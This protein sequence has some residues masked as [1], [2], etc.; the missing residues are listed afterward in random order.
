MEAVLHQTQGG[1]A[2]PGVS[3]DPIRRCMLV[4]RVAE[5]LNDILLLDSVKRIVLLGRCVH[6]A[7]QENE[8]IK[9]MI[10]KTQC[11]EGLHAEAKS[12][13]NGDVAFPAALSLNP[14]AQREVQRV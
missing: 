1:F 8:A 14:G 7:S 11:I 3:F 13:A 10:V 9:E 5:Q 6:E 4:E 12:R 2:K